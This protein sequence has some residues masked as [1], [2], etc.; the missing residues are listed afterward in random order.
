L[1]AALVRDAD[2]RFMVAHSRA[3]WSALMRACVGAGVGVGVGVGAGVGVGVG[4]SM[5]A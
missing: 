2:D 1:R 3:S 4:V 5:C